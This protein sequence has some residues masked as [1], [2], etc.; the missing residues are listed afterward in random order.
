MLPQISLLDGRP[1]VRTPRFNFQITSDECLGPIASIQD[2]SPT[3]FCHRK[4]TLH[5]V[6]FH[7]H[8][9]Q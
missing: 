4:S 7:L 5:I 3:I 8:R 1:P 6:R 9:R 2:E